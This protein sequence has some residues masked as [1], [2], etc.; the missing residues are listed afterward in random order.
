[1]A[2]TKL[3]LTETLDFF[4]E[5]S[6]LRRLE[7]Q[8]SVL[9]FAGQEGLGPARARV[10]ANLRDLCLRDNAAYLVQP[11]QAPNLEVLKI[12]V[13][14]Y[15][16][17]DNHSEWLAV[18]CPYPN[19]RAVH[20]WFSTVWRECAS[21]FLQATETLEEVML[22]IDLVF[23][24]VLSLTRFLEGLYLPSREAQAPGSSQSSLRL[25]LNVT[26]VEKL[27]DLRNILV[28]SVL[29]IL[30]RFLFLTVI[31]TIPP[32][33]FHKLDRVLSERTARLLLSCNIDDNLL[34][35]S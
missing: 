17:G 15:S 34:Y 6:S 23:T 24:P 10:F 32:D 12:D 25:H 26:I 31:L 22:S 19:L 30:R 4:E 18:P 3:G 13:A 27:E 33:S 1:M 7:L 2:T 14:V 16:G 9:D 8:S 20:I 21:R 28:P 5:C 29:C 11:F 35:L